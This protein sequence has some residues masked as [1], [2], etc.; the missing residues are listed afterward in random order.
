MRSQVEQGE[1][2]ASR[3]TSSQRGDQRLPRLE[4]GWDPGPFVKNAH[5][6]RITPALGLERR[7]PAR[8]R[9]R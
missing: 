7:W 1:L 5:A 4:L 6:V 2:S 3:H 9:G 8:M